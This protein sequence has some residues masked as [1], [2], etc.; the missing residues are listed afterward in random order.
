LIVPLIA[1][2]VQSALVGGI[3]I[4]FAG[5]ALL[6]QYVPAAAGVMPDSWRGVL[7][8]LGLITLLGILIQWSLRAKKDDE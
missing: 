3:L 2:A 6:L 5:R 8:S 1:A 7:L 4:L